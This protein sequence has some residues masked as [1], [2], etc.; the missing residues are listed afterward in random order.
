MNIV[1]RCLFR[2]PAYLY[3]W[4]CGRLLGHRFLLLA[5]TG[6]H[7]GAR[8]HTVLEVL[9]YRQDGPEFVVMSGFGRAV[10]WVRNIE[11]TADAEVLSG[12]D[13]FTAAHRFLGAEEAVRVIAAYERGNRLAAPLVRLV[14]SRLLGWHYDGSD[15]ERRRLVAQLPLV[16]FQPRA[17]DWL[18]GP[19]RRDPT[20]ASRTEADQNPAS[21][22][23]R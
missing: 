18:P 13:S 21:G 14:L 17:G 10:D 19:I 9:A 12:S 7:S 5:H 1:L 8:H 15:D 11:A 3:R 16:A 22:S 2:A 6:R 4:R 20:G 23:A